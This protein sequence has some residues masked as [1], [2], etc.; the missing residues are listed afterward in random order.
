MKRNIFTVFTL[1]IIALV[2]L[3][4]VSAADCGAADNVS[5]NDNVSFTTGDNIVIDK[6]SVVDENISADVSVGDENISD[7]PVKDENISADVPAVD[8]N[9]STDVIGHDDVIDNETPVDD[10]VKDENDHG[11][12]INNPKDLDV[13]IFL[14]INMMY[15]S[16]Y[17]TIE[18]GKE[19]NMSADEV[20]SAVDELCVVPIT[21]EKADYVYKAYGTK[22]IAQMA[23]ELGTGTTKLISYL[24]I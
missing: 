16:G 8:E 17:S 10:V 5:Q 24:I 6:V 12:K 2:G 20:Q 11:P 3:G 9:N 19:F 21:N 1:M 14:K 13:G 15:M 7:V 18:I 23:D 22:T 4:M